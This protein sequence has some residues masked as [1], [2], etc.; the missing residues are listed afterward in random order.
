[1]QLVV[2]AEVDV[3]LLIDWTVERPRG[4]LPV[5]ARRLHLVAEQ[6]ELRIAVAPRQELAPGVLGIV[7][8]ER[9]ELDQ[10]I[11]LGRRLDGTLGGRLLAT[12]LL[13]DLREEG[14]EVAAGDQAEESEYQ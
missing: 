1:A 7:E 14:Q 5:A 10:A 6:H 9:D 8:D 2:E 11:L 12:A 13:R 4:R 3:D